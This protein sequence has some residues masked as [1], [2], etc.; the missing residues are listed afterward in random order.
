MNGIPYIMLGINDYHPNISTSSTM[1]NNF[2][3]IPL[4]NK[5]VGTRFT[6]SNDLKEKKGVYKLG[7]T[8]SKIDQLA[9]T[10]YRPDGSLYEFNGYDHQI[11]LRVMRKD[12][13][14]FS[15]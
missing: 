15:V 5:Q 10:I 3:T 13:Q 8:Q 7:P 1:Y 14:N 6:I 2:I 4:E 12:T 11:V 9:I